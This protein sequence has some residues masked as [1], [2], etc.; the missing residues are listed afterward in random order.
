MKNQNKDITDRTVNYFLRRNKCSQYSV[1]GKLLLRIAGKRK[2]GKAP[3]KCR[4]T[5]GKIKKIGKWED[6][7]KVKF[8]DPDSQ[9]TKLNKFSVEDLADL[10]KPNEHEIKRSKYYSKLLEPI[11]R[12]DR[13]QNFKDQGFDLEFDPPGDGS[14]QSGVISSQLASLGIHRRSQKVRNEIIRYLTEHSTDQDGRPLDLW[15]HNESF[16]GYFPKMSRDKIE[17]SC[18]SLQC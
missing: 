18:R 14:C 2:N 13:Y 11:T 4:I 9:S 1:N 6:C 3:R 5:L 15:M 10:E 8:H 12:E 16:S 7:Y 17:I